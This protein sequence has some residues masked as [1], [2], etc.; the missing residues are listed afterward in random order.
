M[1]NLPN[2]IEDVVKITYLTPENCEFYLTKNGFLALKA[3]LPDEDGNFEADATDYKRVYLHRAFPF[4]NP[5]L[6]ISV[7]GFVVDKKKLAEQ[8]KQKAEEAEKAKSSESASADEPKAAETS[9]PKSEETSA[10]NASSTADAK[11]TA[12]SADKT[13]DEKK[14]DEKKDD[15]P[16]PP[17]GEVK[18]IG[19][20][21]DISTFDEKSRSYLQAELDRKYFSPKLLTIA[22]IKE[23][24]GFSYWE[25]ETT[26]GKISFTVQDTYRSIFKVDEDR[27]IISDVDGNRYEIL[28]LDNFD[29][30]SYKKIELYL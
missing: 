19:L 22:S 12:P 2:I 30:K 10:D 29:K 24:H 14:P 1:A 8:E 3:R 11:D 6:Y 18:E 5:T 20:I 23:R 15:K 7:Q 25:T 21:Q 16:A 4:D 9:E 26:S 13:C 28:S 27:I 17:P